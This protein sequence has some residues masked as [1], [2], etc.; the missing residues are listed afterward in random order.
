MFHWHESDGSA[1]LNYRADDLDAL[2]KVLNEEGVEIDPHREDCEFGRFAG[3]MDP[4]GIESSCGSRR[5]TSH[6]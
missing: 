3:I 4:E 1:T 5:K 2:L 6:D